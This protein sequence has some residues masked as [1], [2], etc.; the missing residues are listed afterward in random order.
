MGWIYK[1]PELNL[2]Y[3]EQHQSRVGFTKIEWTVSL[4]IRLQN[5]IL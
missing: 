5:Y 2:L 3:D 4:D 1:I